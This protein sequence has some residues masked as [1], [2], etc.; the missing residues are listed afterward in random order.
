M[1]SRLQLNN[2]TFYGYRAQVLENRIHASYA[3]CVFEEYVH[4]LTYFILAY[5]YARVSLYTSVGCTLY[6]TNDWCVRVLV[7]GNEHCI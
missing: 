4:I 7:D 2:V 3:R 5:A 6:D 1:V